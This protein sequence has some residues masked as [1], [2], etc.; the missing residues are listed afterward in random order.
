MSALIGQMG[1][2]L[3]EVSEDCERLRELIRQ[4]IASHRLTNRYGEALLLVPAELWSAVC[5]AVGVDPTDRPGGGP[6]RAAGEA[7][8]GPAAAGRDI[9]GEPE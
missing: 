2:A 8:R 9:T 3:A 5:A 6:D 1:Q 7:A 4:L